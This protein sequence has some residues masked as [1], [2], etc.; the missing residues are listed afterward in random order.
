MYLYI[1]TQFVLLFFDVGLTVAYRSFLMLAAQFCHIQLSCMHG[2]S[3]GDHRASLLLSQ[4]NAITSTGCQGQR[5]GSAGLECSR[6]CLWV[7]GRQSVA[8][9]HFIYHSLGAV[10]LCRCLSMTTSPLVGLHLLFSLCL[11]VPLCVSYYKTLC[12]KQ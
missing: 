1:T 9:L 4:C 6:V 10:N 2:L 7:D 3:L 8:C 5:A 11:L 12:D